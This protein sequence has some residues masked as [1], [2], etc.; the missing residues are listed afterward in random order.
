MRGRVDG[1]LA[2]LGL[3]HLAHRVWQ[4]ARYGTVSLI[5]TA[6]SMTVLGA[7]VATATLTPGWANIVATGVGTVPSFE[8]NRRWVWGRTGRRSLAAEIGPFCVLSFAGL[9][10]STFLVATV[11]QWATAAGLDAF[12]RTAAVEVAN[13]AAF[14]SLWVLQFLVL[15][16]VLFARR[17]PGP[18]TDGSGA[19]DEGPLPACAGPMAVSVPA[20]AAG[21]G[22][23]AHAPSD[24]APTDLAPAVGADGRGP[25]EAPAAVAAHGVALDR[26]VVP[27]PPAPPGRIPVAA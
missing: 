26:D 17:G 2:R 5:A 7:L 6:T 21:A 24:L 20:P 13:L 18:R 11:G 15:D 1:L 16:R 19:G 23:D 14:G 9:A 8:L 4:L 12:W 27:A 3:G 10:L 25:V 22:I